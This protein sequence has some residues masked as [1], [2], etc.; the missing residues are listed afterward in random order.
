MTLRTVF[1]INIPI[2]VFFGITCLL[3]PNWLF[4][5]YG[6]ELTEPGIF[7]TQL[8]GAAYLGFGALAMQARS[9]ASKEFRLAAALAL[10]VQDSIG[11]I[12]SIIG[13]T[14]GY[15]NSMGWTT[16]AVYLLLALG[17][18]YFRFI[19]PDKA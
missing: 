7:M 13:Q 9:A 1:S 19:R 12:V 14:S 5:L 10:F 6:V 11:A 16:V 17:Y 15:F 2:S 8:A 3:L 18:G 4:S